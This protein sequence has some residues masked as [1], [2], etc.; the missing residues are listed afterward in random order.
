MTI[1]KRTGLGRPMTWSELDANWDQ[2]ESSTTAAQQSAALASASESAAAD[3]ATAA[4]ASA[5]TA[6]DQ[7]TAAAALRTDLASTEEGKGLSLSVAEDGTTGQGFYDKADQFAGAYEDAVITIT[8]ANRFITYNGKRWYVN[9]TVTLPFT[10]TGLNAASWETD[11]ANFISIGNAPFGEVKGVYSY[12][13]TVQTAM[14]G[15]PAG[16]V[17]IDTNNTIYQSLIDNNTS[18]PASGS[19]WS[20]IPNDISKLTLL[21]D[22]AASTGAE[23]VHLPYGNVRNAVMYYTPEMFV[24]DPD[25][26]TDWSPIINL[27]L[28]QAYADGVTTVKGDKVYQGSSSVLLDNFST[29][30]KL[31]LGGFSANSDW[32]SY[33]DWKKAT[34]AF[35]IGGSSN[36]SQ[37]GLEVRLGFFY[38][39]DKAT[40]Y[41]LNGYGAGGSV[42]HCGK[43]RNY[44]I[45]YQCDNSTSSGSASNRVSGDYWYNGK[46]GFRVKRGNSTYIAEGHK[47]CIGF[48]TNNIYGGGQLF[49]GAQYF[50]VYGTDMDFNGKYLAE[51]KVDKAP[52]S[53]IRGSNVTW[54]GV[55]YEVVDY[56][57]LTRGSYCILVIDS[58]ETTG[59][60]ST[61]VTTT[62]TALTDG[63]TTYV[64]SSVRTPTKNQFYFD[65]IHGFEGSSFARGDANFGYLG[66]K[67]GGLQRTSFLWWHNSFD[68]NS[69]EINGL[70]I[71]NTSSAMVFYDKWSGLSLASWDTTSTAA[72]LT[73]PGNLTVSGLTSLSGN[74]S[75]G[76]NRVYGVQ[77][78]TTLTKSTAKSIRTFSYVG[79][80]ASTACKERWVVMMSGPNGISGVGGT[81]EV[82]VGSS[83]I[84]LINNNVSGVTLS[85]SGY[86]LSATQA[87]QDTM[88]VS[89]N[90][91]RDM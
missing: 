47:F 25:S 88:A 46:V 82:Y 3:S 50:Q 4:A 53:D 23:L 45:G 29:G 52:A 38:G 85:A 66:G 54:N 39:A 60:N 1:T 5:A 64:I 84:E 32:P 24:T 63:T 2:V 20:V 81:C 16:S 41:Q 30:L 58:Q 87:S 11:S 72:N 91:K 26:V 73:L 51:L 76:S 34:P 78:A 89:F 59:G 14:G 33:T 77:Y 65:F 9:P 22:L 36:G 48:I 86:L 71:R 21:S 27:A 18:T 49:N 10:T 74:L 90:F 43:A 83:G 55:T 57:Q 12:D 31:D 61:I 17:I 42:F 15:Y 37:V 35:N 28:K 44:V 79:D 13:S 8:S 68:E 6:S 56:Y 40:M 69:N 80:G 67:V 7:A 62:S 70:W 19:S 75:L